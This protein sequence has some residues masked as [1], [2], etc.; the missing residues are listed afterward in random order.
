MGVSFVLMFIAGM[1]CALA[2]ED[3]IGNGTSYPVLVVGRFLLAC[4][5]RGI[6]VTGFVM[7]TSKV[8]FI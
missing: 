4:A 2:P 1:I 6:A 7:G 5:T 8:V 3:L